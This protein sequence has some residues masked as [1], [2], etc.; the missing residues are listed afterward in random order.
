MSREWMNGRI[1][2]KANAWKGDSAG[3]VAKHMWI[4]K[5]YGKAILCENNS[6]HTSTR[7]EW[8]NLSGAYK[9]D[10]SDYKQLCKPCHLRLD[11]KKSCRRG[12]KYTDETVRINSR[13]HKV[14]RPCQ[15]INQHNYM[16]KKNATDY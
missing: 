7:F 4:S 12:H 1:G 16:E 6:S 11:A 15:A 8:A 3:Y 2:D 9:R 13:G 14:C 5:H 10:R